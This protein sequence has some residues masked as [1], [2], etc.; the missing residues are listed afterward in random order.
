MLES[1]NDEL[2]GLRTEIARMEALVSHGHLAAS[3]THE[4]KNA[5]TGIVGFSQI[6][7]KITAN[8][9]KVQELLQ[10]IEREALRCKEILGNFLRS[11]TEGDT[12]VE[13]IEINSLVD[14]TQK[15]VKHHLSIHGV[16]LMVNLDE[17]PFRVRINPG[18]FKQVILN[19]VINA[20]QAMGKKGGEV[21][22]WTEPIPD[23]GVS[24]VVQDSGPG[25]PE[26]VREKIF[27]P[28][29]STKAA[30]EGTGLGLH[31][32]SE[33]IGRAGGKLYLAD[34]PSG[35]A[36]FRIDLPSAQCPGATVSTGTRS[37]T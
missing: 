32:S 33:I 24:V 8:P 34:T 6:A 15:L 27:E 20:Q 3:I 14:E 22:I 25:V 4:V 1:L 30:G 2:A 36:T 26:A 31:V 21:R 35:G 9:A 23:G 37:G 18:K 28:F 19:L 16:K 7:Q 10:F 29:F 13:E 5:M 17:R 12:E 11:A